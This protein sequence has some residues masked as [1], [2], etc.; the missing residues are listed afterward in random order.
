MVY[1]ETLKSLTSEIACPKSF[2]CNLTESMTDLELLS[3]VFGPNGM[4]IPSS[5]LLLIRAK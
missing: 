4:E 1:N 5:R 3:I 2:T